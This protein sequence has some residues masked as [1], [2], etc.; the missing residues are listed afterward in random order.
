MAKTPMLYR[1]W[2][3]A[4]RPVI[5]CWE[6]CAALPCDAAS[7][8]KSALDA[9]LLRSVQAEVASLCGHE[10][11]GVLWGFE[12]FF[13]T[14]DLHVMVKEAAEVG[15][16]V[17]DMLMALQV[18]VG[19]RLLQRK[20]A[21]SESIAPVKSI[22]AGCI[23]SVAFT[24]V[25]VRKSLEG[26]VSRN[27]VVDHTVF[28]DDMGQLAKGARLVRLSVCVKRLRLKCLIVPGSCD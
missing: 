9:A 2:G 6:A 8:G 15:F 5:R 12:K 17:S 21:F 20:R 24:R 14:I 18:H 10:F 7:A 22:L 28:V 11:A 4:R 3:I 19:D 27:P 26:L 25:L 1:M 23:Y 16:P 13:D